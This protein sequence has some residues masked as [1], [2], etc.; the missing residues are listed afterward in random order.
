MKL[1]VIGMGYVGCVTAQLVYLSQRKADVFEWESASARSGQVFRD[2]ENAFIISR[3][4]LVKDG[5]ACQ[6]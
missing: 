5:L 4:F 1:S 3:D 2:R 6:L